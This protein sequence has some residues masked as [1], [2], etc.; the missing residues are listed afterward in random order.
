[1]PSKEPIIEF[2][3]ASFNY[4]S[5]PV[6]KNIDL[7]FAKGGFYLLIGPNGG[8]KTT[9]LKL[10][11]GLLSAKSGE[12]T[13]FGKNP[14]MSRLAM[15]YVPQSFLFD[16]VFPINVEEFVLMGCLSQLTWRGTYPKEC[17]Q[18]AHTILDQVELGTLKDRPLG[19][20]SGGQRQR[21][22]LARAL[23][24]DPEILILDEPTSGLD[25]EASSFIIQ[26]LR[27]LK[28]QKTIIM[29]SHM[30]S[31]V[32]DEVDQVIIVEGQTEIITKEAACAHY[33]LGMYHNK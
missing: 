8:G 15:G 23:L 21:A 29:V 14:M 5:L 18:K 32:I 2:K 24:S 12:V 19:T 17:Y 33:K 20:L 6:L 30:I 9:L 7:A 1:M 3:D 10:I 27:G 31:D 11:M 25:I 22:S 13:V 16:P 4:G 26:Q 28:H